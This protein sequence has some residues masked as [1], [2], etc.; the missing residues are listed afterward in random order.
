MSKYVKFEEVFEKLQNE[1]CL[2][3]QQTMATLANIP[4]ADV[5]PVRHGR[6]I[7]MGDFEQ[8][9]C[10]KV[11]RPKE[12]QDYYGNRVI[13]LRTDYCPYCGAKMDGEEKEHE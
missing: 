12:F 6:W 2:T 9:S 4:S 3:F 13:W 5:E 8:C 1:T 10:C 7:D 11:T